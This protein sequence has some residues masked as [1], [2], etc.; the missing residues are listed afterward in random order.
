MTISESMGISFNSIMV[1]GSGKIGYSLSP[2]EKMFAPFCVKEDNGRKISDIDVAIISS[3]LY[4][5]FW[6]LFRK[7]YSSKYNYT[8]QNVYKEIYRG[9]INEK[10]FNR[11]MNVEKNGCLFRLNQKK[12]YQTNYSSNM[13]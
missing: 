9:Y 11:L 5:K 3:D 4:L 1:V 13:K 12:Y 7:S 10:I 6:G 8:Y 2:T